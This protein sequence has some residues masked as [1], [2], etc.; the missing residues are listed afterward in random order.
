MFYYDFEIAG[1]LLRVRSEF[2]LREFHELSYYRVEHRPQRHPDAQYTI[3]A[4]PEDWEI[5]GLRILED[6]QNAIYQWQGEE[7]RY[8]FWNI[9]SQERFILLRYRLD[10]PHDYTIYLQAEDLTRILPQFRLS[11]LFSPERLLLHHSAFQL[12]ASVISWNGNGILFT[13]PSGTGKSTQADLWKRLEGA[14]ILNGDRA[15]IRNENDKFRVYG[16]PYA[17]SSGIYT[18]HSVPIRAIVA[19]SQASENSLRP[20]TAVAAFNQLYRESTVRYW[21]P[22]FVDV[23]SNLLLS[24]IERVPIYHLAC[25][26]DAGAV[27]ILKAELSK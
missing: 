19:L 25:R 12:H 26:P 13:A 3:Q 17:G 11:A 15:I 8:Y 1:L 21:D 2:A 18:N 24:L 14:Q 7:H 5:C 23:F 16:S 9:F 4:L 22:E 10:D 6:R 27:A 20:L